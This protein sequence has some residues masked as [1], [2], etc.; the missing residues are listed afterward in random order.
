MSNST[1][2]TVIVL[3]IS[4]PTRSGKSS[5]ALSL[6]SHFHLPP[7]S[8]VHQ[9][10]FWKPTHQRP[11]VPAG[12]RLKCRY[13]MESPDA[14]DWLRLESAIRRCRESAQQQKNPA[15]RLIVIV[16]GFLL[17]TNERI[18]NLLDRRIFITLPKQTCFERR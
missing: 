8:V 16:E 12:V 17:F 9:D 5:L 3:G 13:N 18:L 15:Q 6:T 7:S 4:G 2:P 10:K 1:K 11:L 14:V